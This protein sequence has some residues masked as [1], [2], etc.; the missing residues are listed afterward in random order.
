MKI[1]NINKLLKFPHFSNI[2]KKYQRG[3]L[4]LDK[5]RFPLY[6]FFINNLKRTYQCWL[7][8]KSF[9]REF[10]PREILP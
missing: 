9:S 2:S 8:R 5:I 7:I 3:N 4:T 6:N 1:N 10:N